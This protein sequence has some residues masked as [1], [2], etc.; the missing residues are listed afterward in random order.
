MRLSYITFLFAIKSIS[1]E[2]KDHMEKRGNPTSV[3][4][5]LVF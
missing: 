5:L 1:N 2:I 3:Y 4:S